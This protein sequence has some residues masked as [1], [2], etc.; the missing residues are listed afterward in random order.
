[1]PSEMEM[2]CRYFVIR[3]DEP[4]LHEFMAPYVEQMDKFWALDRKSS[5][6]MG[7]YGVA[8]NN[9]NGV[10][11]WYFDITCEVPEGLKAYSKYPH[12]DKLPDGR[13]LKIY[14]PAAKKIKES[15]KYHDYLQELN[16]LYCD[17]SK[18]VIEHLDA[19]IEFLTGDFYLVKTIALDVRDW[20]LVV[21]PWPM[22]NT[23]AKVFDSRLKEITKSQ[24][25]AVLEEGENPDELC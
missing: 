21:A 3:K 17:L 14:M 24:Y 1:M 23:S 25:V 5:N 20:W 9:F 16:Q 15:K 7:A 12:D 6:E 4:Q 18:M 13:L 11:G 2:P 19:H 10:T 22:N 8:I